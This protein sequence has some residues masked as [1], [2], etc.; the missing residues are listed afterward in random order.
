M[1]EINLETGKKVC[2]TG[3][4]SVFSVKNNRIV[5][6]KVSE[7]KEKD[8]LVAPLIIPNGNNINNLNLLDEFINLG[9][10]YPNIYLR[11]FRDEKAFIK[12]KEILLRVFNF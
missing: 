4:H 11:N 9:A 7:L 5:P 6:V 8:F 3:N 1:F 10:K 12:L 2:V